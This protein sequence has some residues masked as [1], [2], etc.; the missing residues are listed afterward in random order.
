[1]VPDTL[2][3]IEIELILANP[4][5]DLTDNDLRVQFTVNPG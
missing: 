1:V 4:D 3:E 2:Y 5:S